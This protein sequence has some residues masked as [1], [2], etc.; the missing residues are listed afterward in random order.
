MYTFDRVHTYY[1]IGL[2]YVT[3]LFAGEAPCSFAYSG[4]AKKGRDCKF[5]DFGETFK[6]VGI[7]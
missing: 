6:K 5:E 2:Y 4:S 3:F 7:Y 1:F